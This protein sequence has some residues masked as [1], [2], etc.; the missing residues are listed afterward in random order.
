MWSK[1]QRG[2]TDAA[3][4]ADMA[5]LAKVLCRYLI[6]TKCWC[7]ACYS[8]R[9]VFFCFFF[10]GRKKLP[11][12]RQE[13]VQ[14]FGMLQITFCF[15]KPSSN[16]AQ[17]AFMN[18]H[19]DSRSR[20]NTTQCNASTNVVGV[21]HFHQKKNEGEKCEVVL[22]QYVTTENGVLFFVE[23]RRTPVLKNGVCSPCV[24][25]PSDLAG[26]GRAELPIFK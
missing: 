8:S 10:D 22:S 17:N 1:F 15:E 25:F 11:R 3:K 14:R 24:K 23:S 26:F 13:T 19:D 12:D 2:K 5:L 4:H 18:V 16:L 7:S 9:S 6:L 21:G 20:L